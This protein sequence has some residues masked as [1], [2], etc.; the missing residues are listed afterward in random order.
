MHE[1]RRPWMLRSVVTAHP[2]QHQRWGTE[3]HTPRRLN[4]GR[5]IRHRYTMP[6]AQLIRRSTNPAA[7]LHQCLPVCNQ[8]CTGMWTDAAAAWAALLQ[9]QTKGRAP[10]I[11]ERPQNCKVWR[12][13]HRW[14]TLC[15]A[16]H[17]CQHQDTAPQN[18]TAG[19]SAWLMPTHTHACTYACIGRMSSRA[20][21]NGPS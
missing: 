20:A 19:A 4:R 10:A 14:L 13:H 1:P 2:N 9:P 8:C 16:S 6:P 11:A 17:C 12:R 3:V 21:V 15:L 18:S 5:S 7:M